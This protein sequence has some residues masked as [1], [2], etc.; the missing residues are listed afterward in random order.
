MIGRQVSATIENVT[1]IM[2]E[3]TV[4]HCAMYSV[5]ERIITNQQ[6]QKH[7]CSSASMYLSCNSVSS[8]F[9]FKKITRLSSS[10]PS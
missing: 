4:V 2:E 8:I 6:K 10:D 3:R 1:A 7:T 9:Y 5:I